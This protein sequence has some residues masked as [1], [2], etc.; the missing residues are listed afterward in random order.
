MLECS[1]DGHYF[2]HTTDKSLWRSFSSEPEDLLNE[3]PRM[4]YNSPR[5]L[6]HEGKQRRRNSLHSPEMATICSM[7]KSTSSNE[8]LS[9][10]AATEL[11]KEIATLELEILRL[12]KHLLSL[13]RTAFNC[14]VKDSNTMSMANSKQSSTGLLTDKQRNEEE[15][16][17]NHGFITE[18]SST[19]I[20]NTFMCTEK[21]RAMRFLHKENSPAI[22]VQFD[23]ENKDNEVPIEHPQ[24]DMLEA[25]SLHCSPTN[26]FNDPILNPESLIPCKLSEAVIR[27]IAAIYC[28]I[29]SIPK[30]KNGKVGLPPSLSSS[31]T[32]SQ[33]CSTENWSS[34]RLNE[35]IA[36]PIPSGAWRDEHERCTGFID[37]PR[38]SIDGERFAYASKILSTFRILIKQLK[39]IDPMKMAYEEQLA[40]WL[41][42]H[43]ALVMHAFLAYGLHQGRMKNTSSVLKAAYNVGGHSVNAYVIQSS[44]LGCHPH[45]SAPW[46]ENFLS[47]MRRKQKHVF[48]LEHPQPLIHFAIC[49]GAYSDPVVRVY[50]AKYIMQELAVARKEFIQANVKVQENKKITLPKI[51]YYYMKD[52]CFEVSKFLEM[53]IEQ[54]PEAEQGFI[55]ESLNGISDDCI[56]WLHYKSSFRYLIH[57]DL[58]MPSTSSKGRTSY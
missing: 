19:E 57:R 49:Q 56:E 29:A 15:C 47:F 26:Q 27:C 9:P 5:L 11:V 4:S 53:V 30:L 51:L 40:F 39:K 22:H 17:G 43:N 24:K 31:S 23:S 50:T 45:C 13:Y 18:F 16:Q 33:R 12:E 7:N 25:V 42:I 10:K 38:I 20:N 37:V 32:T 52:M 3:T 36:S 35:A 2:A 1:C 54:M 58:A 21:Q 48:A 6:L 34:G 44:I 8:A 14:Y 41:N 55:Q 46:F 28:K